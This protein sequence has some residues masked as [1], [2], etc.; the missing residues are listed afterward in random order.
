MSVDQ[1]ADN[2]MYGQTITLMR[3]RVPNEGTGQFELAAANKHPKCKLIRGQV[4]ALIY[5]TSVDIIA[6]EHED[7]GDVATASASATIGTPIALT[8]A[9]AAGYSIVFERNEPILMKASTQGNAANATK[10]V[11]VW[12][13]LET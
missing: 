7:G 2:E 9:P 3:M 11:T 10:I 4:T 13:S 1:I 5:N 6:I 12:E 8:I